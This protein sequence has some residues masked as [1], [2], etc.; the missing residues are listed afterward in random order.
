MAGQCQGALG[1]APV[2]GGGGARVPSLAPPGARIRGWGGVGPKQWGG[3]GSGSG[4]GRREEGEWGGGEWEGGSG[5]GGVL[6][7]T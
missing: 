3:G 5:F 6:V 1:A 4:G 7:G 2:A